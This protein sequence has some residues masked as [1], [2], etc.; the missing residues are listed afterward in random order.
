MTIATRLYSALHYLSCHFIVTRVQWRWQLHLRSD[1]F[2]A[3]IDDDEVLCCSLVDLMRSIGYRVE[4]FAS[5]NAFLASPSLFVFDCV[6][7]DVRMPGM[8]GLDLVRK[9]RE[10]SGTSSVILITALA[11]KRR[12]DEAKSVGALRLLGKPF[13]TE[14]LLDWIERSLPNE[15][16]QQQGSKLLSATR[17][18]F[19]DHLKKSAEW[20]S[21]TSPGRTRSSSPAPMASLL[22]RASGRIPQGKTGLVAQ[23]PR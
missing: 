13:E 9:S 15:R 22:A 2:I 4:P 10:Q 12:D 1:H 17:Y 11:D 8:N 19:G 21:R 23:V 14:V 6:I 16:P 5:A 20:T 7:T 18:E 3:I